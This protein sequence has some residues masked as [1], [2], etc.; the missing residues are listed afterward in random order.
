MKFAAFVN[1]S[2]MKALVSCGN[3]P[4]EPSCL[5]APRMDWEE[6][7]SEVTQTHPL[8][9][10]TPEAEFILVYKS[11]TVGKNSGNVEK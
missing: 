3:P 11:H 1:F 6:W 10:H 2:A 5:G 9:T 4:W 7:R 8:H